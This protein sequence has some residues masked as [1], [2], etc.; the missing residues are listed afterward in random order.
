MASVGGVCVGKRYIIDHQ[1]LSGLGY[2]F[3]ASVPPMMA[4][5]AIEALNIMESSPEMFSKL[6]AK[7]ALFYDLLQ[8]YVI[9]GCIM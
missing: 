6:Q 2:C 4:A 5:A 1:R 9:S 7:T 8:Q 3:S